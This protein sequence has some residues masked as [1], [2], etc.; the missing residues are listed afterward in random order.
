MKVSQEPPSDKPSLLPTVNKEFVPPPY[1]LQQIVWDGF[2]RFPLINTILKVPII[3]GKLNQDLQNIASTG[4]TNRPH[5]LSCLSDYTSFDSLTDRTYFGRHLPP[6]DPHMS[7]R[8]P[9]LEELRSFFERPSGQQTMCPKSTLLFPTF[10][11]HLIDSFINTKVD[12]V[13]SSKQG[14]TVFDF[15]RTDSKHQIG[16]S[17]LYG[18][19]I[20]MTTQLR[21]KSEKIGRKGRLKTQV[22]EEGEEWAPFL[23]DASGNVKAEF[24]KLEAPSGMEHVLSMDEK[25]AAAK[26]A[27]VFAFGGP[28][29]N[30][31]PNIVAWN[32]LLLRE[33]NRIAF[34]LEQSEPT[35][36]DERV[37]QTAR[38]VVIV[39]YSKIVVEEYVAHISG[40]DFK[41][42]PGEWMWNAEWY[43]TNWMT[44]EFACL[45]R[46]HAI[47]PN[48]TTWGGTTV[49]IANSLFDN[50]LLLSSKRGCAGKLR[51]I[52]VQISQQRVTAF[53]PGNTEKGFLVGRDLAAVKQSRAC[54]LRSYADYCEYLKMDRPK[55]FRDISGYP[56]VQEKLY[57]LYG[58]VD[59]VEFY[60][61][62]M[63]AD[64]N[65]GKIFSDAM[66]KF[67]A[68]DA[69][70]QALANPLLSEN[71]WKNGEDVFGT[72]GWEEVKKD[73]RI[74]DM[75]ERNT[76]RGDP[77]NS[78]V[79]MTL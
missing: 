73:H 23:F 72:Y 70:N 40:V 47:I 19:Q 44:A 51:D 4:G 49:G 69:F 6:A 20:E 39:I 2:L 3:G 46:W 24:D 54:N 68:N 77:L 58:D 71:V 43:K 67:V 50:T 48:T 55:T 34:G 57:D 18:N 16:L 42:D 5:Q 17:P 60:V 31:N 52:L 27:S 25:T 26:K 62:L 63:A 11:Q 36:D 14:V 75:V 53:I 64:I 45:Y 30:L 61:G 66:T 22:F 41:V 1:T 15:R 13:Q 59:H 76:Q 10:A 74:R 7:K 29:A 12:K 56:D 28:R 32:T 9:S 38:N 21:E 78:F 8:L 33:H 35:W 65:P 79:G 37:F